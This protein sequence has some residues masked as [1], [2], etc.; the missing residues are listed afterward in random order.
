MTIDFN[1]SRGA[2]DIVNE[3][4][5][6]ELTQKNTPANPLVPFQPLWDLPWKSSAAEITKDQALEECT[7]K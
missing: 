7:Q 2:V 4:A 3:Q 1:W 5:L 6:E